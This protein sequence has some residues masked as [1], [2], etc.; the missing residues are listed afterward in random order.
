MTSCA[1]FICHK[2]S[3]LKHEKKFYIKMR[4]WLINGPKNGFVLELI[5]KLIFGVGKINLLNE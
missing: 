4:E 1:H 2:S 3:I 5:W